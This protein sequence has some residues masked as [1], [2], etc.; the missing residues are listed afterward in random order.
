MLT[1][2]DNEDSTRFLSRLSKWLKTKT[3]LDLTDWEICF[4]M[5]VIPFVVIFVERVTQWMGISGVDMSVTEKATV[6]IIWW[7]A[8]AVMQNTK[9]SYYLQLI[10][11]KQLHHEREKT[12]RPIILRSGF[13]TSWDIIHYSVNEKNIIEGAPLT[14]QVFDHIATEIQGIIV[15]NG[16]RYA[17]VFFSRISQMSDIRYY[18]DKVWRGWIKPDTELYAFFESSKGIPVS[19]ENQICLTYKDIEGNSFYTIENQN[20]IQRCHRGILDS[21]AHMNT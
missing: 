15:Q 20:F 7:T 14:F 8:G 6:C 2:I 21:M 19:E 18:A 9:A 17:L 5:V 16:M 4:Y 1:L 12:L 11:Q 3:T 10:S 13:I